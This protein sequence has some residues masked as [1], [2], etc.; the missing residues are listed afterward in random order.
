MAGYAI[1]SQVASGGFSHN[2][3][4]KGFGEYYARAAGDQI[5]GAYLTEAM[6]PALLH[7]DP[8]YFRLGTGSFW[9]RAYY[10]ASRIVFTRGD[11]GGHRLFVSELA[12]NA[13]VVAITTAYYPSSRSAGEAFERYSQQLGNDAISNELTEFWPDVKRRLHFQRSTKAI[14]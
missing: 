1:Q 2:G 5:I 4:W 3:G 6:M 14:D 9:Y 10:A 11:N 12:G 8:R 13:A 7:E